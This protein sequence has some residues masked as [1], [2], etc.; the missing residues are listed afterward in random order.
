M[1]NEQGGRGGGKLRCCLTLIA[2]TV[3]RGARYV[4][5]VCLRA[6]GLRARAVY[7]CAWC[8]RCPALNAPVP[9]PARHSVTLTLP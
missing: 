6:R 9:S 3:A 1:E 4:R 7:V 5:D 2:T 8:S